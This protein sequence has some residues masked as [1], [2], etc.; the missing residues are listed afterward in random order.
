MPP[1]L[2]LVTD[3]SMDWSNLET[4]SLT[5]IMVS[6]PPS[7]AT[8]P[9]PP[10][11][12]SVILSLCAPNIEML[13]MS[14]HNAQPISFALRFPRLRSLDL[15]QQKQLDTAALR[16]LL[17][18]SPHLST[19]AINYGHAE[20]RDFLNQHARIPSL[21]TV[22]LHFDNRWD[23][24][25]DPSLEFI[26]HCRQ[27]EAFA[28][29]GP[30]STLVNER[31][32]F[33]LGLNQMPRLRTLSMGWGGRKIP[34]SA[35]DAIAAL[36]SSSSSSSLQALH[37]TAASAASTHGPHHDWHRAHPT[38]A[39]RLHPLRKL[40]RIAFTRDTYSYPP[41][42]DGTAAAAAADDAADADGA[43]IRRYTDYL[44]MRSDHWDVH[45]QSMR[46]VALLY[47][48]AFPELEFVHVGQRSFRLSRGN[49]HDDETVH[50]EFFLWKHEWFGLTRSTY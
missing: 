43:I 26:Q 13:K 27:V 45:C 38:I 8:D 22:V 14:W 21:K 49:I 36:P 23:L 19:L 9:Q 2:R 12:W 5:R 18:T 10:P 48:A 35:L 47:A 44:R 16:S 39:A 6:Q 11:D 4:L 28:F 33:L 37:L 25:R 41:R 42:L 46:S 15:A 3:A 50:E 34:E 40:R 30:G 17:L 1:T 20:T 29:D 32:L 24:A 31:V 7:W